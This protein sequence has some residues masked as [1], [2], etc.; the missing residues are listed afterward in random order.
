MYQN[1]ILLPIRGF[2]RLKVIGFIM[3][4][5]LRFIADKAVKHSI[6]YKEV[7]KDGNSPV[8]GTL[9]VQKWFAKESDEILL[10]IQRV[11]SQKQAD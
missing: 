1:L 4:K 8:V 6:R 3:E 7:V 5:K 2:T 10:Q 9:Y 11:D